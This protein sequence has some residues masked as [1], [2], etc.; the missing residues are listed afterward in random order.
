MEYCVAYLEVECT[1][2]SVYKWLRGKMLVNSREN[3]NSI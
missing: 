1:F 3:V 2:V